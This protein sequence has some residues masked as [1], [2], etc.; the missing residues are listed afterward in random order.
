MPDST[1][2]PDLYKWASHLFA[3]TLHYCLL[4]DSLQT[5]SALYGCLKKYNKSDQTSNPVKSDNY[6]IVT[7]LI[8]IITY[9]IIIIMYLIII[10]AFA[11]IIIDM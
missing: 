5:H 3:R 7:Y 8:I 1:S 10:I 11:F 4:P 2:H 9:L 6:H